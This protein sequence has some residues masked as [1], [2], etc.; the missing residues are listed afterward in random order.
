MGLNSKLHG[1][2]GSA[3]GC[4]PRGTGQGGERARLGGWRWR[5]GGLVG[6]EVEGKGG[7]WSLWSKLGEFWD[8]IREVQLFCK[9]T[10]AL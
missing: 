8:K 10:N 5:V 6:R 9:I 1:E 7:C 3:D 2:H 4:D